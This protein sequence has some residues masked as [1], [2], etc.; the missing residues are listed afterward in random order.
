MAEATKKASSLST[1]E[2]QLLAKI[3]EANKLFEADEKSLKSLSASP[4]VSSHS[5]KG[6]ITSM[7]SVTSATSQFSNLPFEE[8]PGLKANSEDS[9]E[10]WGRIVNDWESYSKK[11]PQYIKDL[12]RKGI[13]HHFRGLV[14]QLLCNAYSSPAKEQYADLLKRSSPYEKVIRRD[15]ARTYPE[16]DFFKEKD[17]LGQESLFNVMKAYSLIDREVG[18][19][20][21]SGFIVGLLLMQMP[22]E[23]AFAVLVTLMFDYKLRDLFKPHMFELGLCMFKLE[24]MLQDYLPDLYMH[25]QGQG[26]HTSIYASSWFLTLFTTALPLSVACRIMDIFISEGFEIIFRVAVAILC[27]NQVDLLAQDMEGMLRCIQKEAPSRH[28]LDPDALLQTAFQVKINSKKMKKL[29]KEYT[30]IKSKEQE[31]Q[32]ELRRLRTENR[33]L[34]QRVDN[35]E[36]ETGTLADRLVQDQVTRA[37]E[38]EEMFA[39]RRDLAGLKTQN[40]CFSQGLEE[41]NHVIRQLK[42]QSSQESDNHGDQAHMIHRLQTEL[43]TAKQKENDAHSAVRDLKDQIQ[44]LENENDKLQREPEMTIVGLQEELIAV[45]LREAESNLSMKEMR[46][47]INDLQQAYDIY[48]ETIAD[49]KSSRTNTQHLHDE[50]MAVKLREAETSAD[51]KTMKQKVMELETQNQICSHQIQR[52]DDENTHLKEKMEEAADREKKLRSEIK[53]NERKLGDNESR[54]R[55]EHMMSRIK[56]AEHLQ[57]VAEMRQR[58]AELEIENQELLTASQLRTLRT[59][60]DGVNE[61]EDTIAD[62]QEEVL[63]LRMSSSLSRMSFSMNQLDMD[64]DTDEDDDISR[65]I[66]DSR[67]IPESVGL[68]DSYFTPNRQSTLTRNKKSLNNNEKESLKMSSSNSSLAKTLDDSVET[69]KDDVLPNG[70]S[71]PVPLSSEMDLGSLSGSKIDSLPSVDVVS[72]SESGVGTIENSDVLDSTSELDT[73]VNPLHDSDDSLTDDSL[74]NGT[75]NKDIKDIL[76]TCTANSDIIADLMRFDAKEMPPDSD[77]VDVL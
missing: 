54:W 2:I 62:L 70:E 6:S 72:D 55:E 40:E 57:T 60:G 44:S 51:L 8:E 17:G 16:H 64:S 20:Q 23:E 43:V 1:E 18:Y 65:A 26:F 5:R 32:V 77:K 19:C 67:I 3:E 48:M 33:L 34:R 58:I 11:K 45:K 74:V 50:L 42:Q 61:L 68:T 56:D 14:W 12:V 49:K 69:V 76:K 24:C 21:G 31:E 25:F 52:L 71:H 9:W 27:Q 28:E 46:K 7:K 35:L 36:K 75:A 10:V 63:Q 73:Y 30:V 22:E 4:N 13:P 41:A 15:I 38:A 39:V 37:Q 29:E 59:K 47:L 53:D 66:K